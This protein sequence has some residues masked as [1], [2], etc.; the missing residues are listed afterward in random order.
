MEQTETRDN[1]SNPRCAC[2]RGLT[3]LTH[4]IRSTVELISHRDVLVPPVMFVPGRKHPQV[5]TGSKVLLQRLWEWREGGREGVRGRG[6]ER[7]GERE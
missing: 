1:Y 5:V 7:E 2:H 3:T 4:L 6:S